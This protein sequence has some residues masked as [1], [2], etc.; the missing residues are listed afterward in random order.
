MRRRPAR[1]PQHRC[2]CPRGS[3]VRRSALRGRRHPGLPGHLLLP[4]RARTASYFRSA[5]AHNTAELGG[6]SQSGEDGPFRWV[7]FVRILARS[8]YSMMATSP[9][10][11]LSTAGTP[12]LTRR[13]CI[14]ARCCW[15]GHRAASTSSIRSTAAATTSVWPSISDP[16]V[17]AE[18]D[19]SL[20]GPGLAHR[21]HTRGG[22]AGTAAGAAVEPAPG[23]DRSHPRLVLPWPG[24][25]RSRFTLLGCG[26]CVPGMPLITRLEFLDAGNSGKSAVSRQAISWTASAALSG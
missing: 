9:D 7:A 8:R 10:G 12:R 13:P 14:A 16:D 19:E 1:V 4:R 3:S 23:R 20:R 2:A 25:T 5:I 18:L 15:T 6:R 24:P 26:R 21:I 22:P 11:R 17:R